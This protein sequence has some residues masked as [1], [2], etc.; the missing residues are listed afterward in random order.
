MIKKIT[1]SKKAQFGVGGVGAI[2]GLVEWYNL[3]PAT[4]AICITVITS[5]ELMAWL[6]QDTLLPGIK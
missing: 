3:D 1:Q 6:L 5:I 2:L 4:A